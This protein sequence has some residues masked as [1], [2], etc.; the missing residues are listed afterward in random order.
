MAFRCPRCGGYL[1]L[2]TL[3]GVEVHPC[4]R[5]G[6]IWFSKNELEQLAHRDPVVVRS[7]GALQDPIPEPGL[8]VVLEGLLCPRCAVPLRQFHYFWAPD[9][10]LDGCPSCHG[11]WVDDGELARLE[12]AAGTGAT[13]GL[14]GKVTTSTG[15]LE[16][17]VW[18]LR[19][20]IHGGC[21]P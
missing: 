8:A 14:A 1:S 20:L 4:P 18:K 21:R 6:G 17:R 12:E 5:C 15:T 7:L 9:L 19:A 11:V 16:G 2:N 13:P 3:A 10:A